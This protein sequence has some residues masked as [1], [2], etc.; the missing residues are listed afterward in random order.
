ML[1]THRAERD[2]VIARGHTLLQGI[3]M[4]HQDVRAMM[5]ISAPRVGPGDLQDPPR[6]SRDL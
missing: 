3:T 4:G 1:A 6:Q 5:G 2:V